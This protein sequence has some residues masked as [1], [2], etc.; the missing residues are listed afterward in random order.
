MANLRKTLTVFVA[1]IIRTAGVTFSSMPVSAA[2][3]EAKFAMVIHGGAGRI[4]KKNLSPEKEAEYRAKL[5]E[6]LRTG[7]A[8]LA[9]GGSALDAVVATIQV[10]ENS[11]LFNAGKG[12]VFAHEGQN[13][14]DA[15]IMDG[16]NQDAGAVASVTHI[17][18]PIALAREV[19]ENS[20]HVLLS[21]AG[22]E[23]FAQTRG[24]KLVDPSYFATEKRLQQL[25][26][27]IAREKT[28]SA[29]IPAPT[30]N[31][32][33][34]PD[35]KFGTVGA[36]ALDKNGNI[37][38]GTSTGGMTNK[39]WKRIGDTPII[40]A[41]TYANNASCG[42]SSTGHGEFF[43]R[44]SVAF[45]IC[46]MMEYKGISLKEAADAIIM[47]KLVKMG[48]AGGIVSLDKDGN[49]AMTF[50]TEGMYRGYIK[51]GGDPVTGIY[52]TDE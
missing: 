11:P 36:V 3:D 42:V 49:I 48:G 2:E 1:A 30:W 14:L 47:T 24:I 25:K 34:D 4:L 15:S 18:S 7:Q 17:K 6:A 26:N 23:E 16:S 43:I 35:N 12:A 51:G 33:I 29:I 22:A 5:E 50:N 44:A 28:S 8:I 9:S 46:A 13:E 21:G 20:A 41:G 37:A 19:M 52:G 38:A 32:P 40:G 45:S 31:D 10:M 27:A 39:R